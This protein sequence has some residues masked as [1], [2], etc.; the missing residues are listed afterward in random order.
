MEER[1]VRGLFDDKS[2]CQSP[3]R[4]SEATCFRGCLPQSSKFY[5]SPLKVGSRFNAQIAT[6][7]RSNGVNCENT[8]TPRGRGG[9]RGS[10]S[11]NCKSCLYVSAFVSTEP[12]SRSVVWRGFTG[13]L[14]SQAINARADFFRETQGSQLNFRE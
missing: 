7:L 8:S 14:V 1:A 11:Q 6:A 2:R 4:V 13:T 9:R 12:F 5:L 3:L 10:S